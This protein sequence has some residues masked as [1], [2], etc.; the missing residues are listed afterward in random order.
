MEEFEVKFLKVDPDL[1]QK[2][3]A[4]LGAEKVGDFFQQWKSFDYPDWRLDT[5]GAWIRLR[6]GGNGKVTLAF[7]QR[8]GIQSADGSVNDAG[9]DEVEVEVSDF[10][11][12]V[13]ML[14][15]IGFVIKHHGEKKRTQWKMGSL[16]FDFDAYPGLAPYLEIEGSSW[17]EVQKAVD[18]LGL[19]PAEQ[20]I[21]SANQVFSLQGIDVSKLVR[22]SFADGLVER[23]K[24]EQVN[25][26][27]VQLGVYRHFKGGEYQ[28]ISVA[29]DSELAS[30]ELAV[31]QSLADDSLWVRPLS[32]FL[33]EVDR[34]EYHGPRFKWVREE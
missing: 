27:S 8:L 3:L 30:R 16:E 26:E 34:D 13:E 18:L 10:E 14:V 28:L 25:P 22:I 29:K 4:E 5:A 31:Y 9:M 32:M 20:K 15:K 7:K 17:E 24:A 6:D 12:T 23:A 21:C 11:Q 1:V 19:N 33:E 2:Q